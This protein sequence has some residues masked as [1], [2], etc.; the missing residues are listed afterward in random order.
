MPVQVK[1]RTSSASIPPHVSPAA[2]VQGVVHLE[3]GS[4]VGFDVKPPVPQWHSPPSS[5]AAVLNPAVLHSS[6][7]DSLVC[8]LEVVK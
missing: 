2:P 1:E 4:I 8:V 7:H 3:S 6:A 5:T